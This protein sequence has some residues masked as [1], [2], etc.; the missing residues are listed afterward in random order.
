MSG[1]GPRLG[2]R[3]GEGTEA[4]RLHPLTVLLEVGRV[5]GRVLWFFV[6]LM[7]VGSLGGR[8]ADPGT[9]LFVLAGSGILVAL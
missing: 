4:R 5:L 3:P 8:R 2:P 1:E 7:V 6:V 9:W